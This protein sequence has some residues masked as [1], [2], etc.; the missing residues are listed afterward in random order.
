MS[1][2]SLAVVALASATVASVAT[3][4]TLLVRPMLRAHRSG[5]AF[6]R[7]RLRVGWDKYADVPRS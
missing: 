2:T 7:M 1:N 6:H 5:L 4:A 3:M